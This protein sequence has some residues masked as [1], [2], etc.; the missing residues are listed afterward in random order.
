MCDVHD[1][2][3]GGFW[4]AEHEMPAASGDGWHGFIQ[5][6]SRGADMAVFGTSQNNKERLSVRTAKFFYAAS[7]TPDCIWP[8]WSFAIEET[9]AAYGPVNAL[10]SSAIWL[11]AGAVS[12]FRPGYGLAFASNEDDAITLCGIS[13]VGSAL[14]FPIDVV[15][16]VSKGGNERAKG[17]STAAFYWAMRTRV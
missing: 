13:E 7:D 5:S 8:Q 11:A 10:A 14:E 1:E 4:F 3:S 16:E 9:R 2:F 12:W 17:F 6:V 15:T